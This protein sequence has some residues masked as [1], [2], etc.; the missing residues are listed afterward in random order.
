MATFSTRRKWH[1]TAVSLFSFSRYMM[2]TSFLNT[3]LGFSWI[4]VS[5]KGSFRIAGLYT[6]VP[7]SC[8]MLRP[9]WKRAT[10]SFADRF[11]KLN[12]SFLS[13]SPCLKVCDWV[14]EL[15]PIKLPGHHQR[16]LL[17]CVWWQRVTSFDFS[18]SLTRVCA[19]TSTFLS[20]VIL[21]PDFSVFMWC[22][23]VFQCCNSV[24]CLSRWRIGIICWCWDDRLKAA[25]PNTKPFCCDIFHFALPL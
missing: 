9:K 18:A 16:E 17:E 19:K 6:A 12:L 25:V 7:G 22:V 13:K 14:A 3:F 10:C 24:K 8:D 20:L 21:N 5:H 15:F 23:A 11:H 2:I 4:L 1:I